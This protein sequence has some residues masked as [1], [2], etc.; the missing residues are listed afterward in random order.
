MYKYFFIFCLFLTFNLSAEVVKKI[1]V[2]GNDR[3][4]DQTVIV[5]GEI[6]L[7]EDYGA[8][9]LDKILKN[10][11]K[12]N[13]FEDVNLNLNNG[14]FKINVKE[15]PIISSIDLRGEKSKTIKKKVLEQLVLKEKESFIE[16]KL[17]QDIEGLKKIYST[18]G[19]NFTTVEAKVEK[20]DNNRIN[21]IYSLNK[22]KKIKISKINFIGNKI[23]RERKLRDIIAS[24]ENRFWKFLSRNTFLNY[25]NIE[26]D[27]RLLLNYY[28]SLGYYD[29]QV[30]S[31]NAEISKLDSTI[32]TYT[33]NA[34]TRY[35]I[36]KISANVSNVLNKKLFSPLQKDFTKIVGK[37]YS[38]FTVKKLLD[39]LDVLI[40]D[41]DLQFIEHSVNEILENEDIEIKINIYEGSKQLVE[42]INIT[43]NSVTDESVIRSELLLDE[44][45]PFNSLKLSKS[46]SRLK[47]R[48]LFS[49][50]KEVIID[51]SS[52]NQK[53]VEIKV[54]EMPTGEISAGA[55][56]GTSGGSIS[57]NLTENN[58]LGRGIA[59]TTFVDASKTTFSGGVNVTD[60]NYKFS[61]NS[62]NYF[63]NN[64]TND[65]PDSGFK[66]SIISTGVGTVFE[67]FKN[68]FISP[69]I[70]L[71][72]D[73]MTVLGT[74]SDG[75]KKQAGSFSDVNLSYKISEDTRNRTYGPTDGDITSFSQSLPLY[76][77]SPYLR[78]TF[79]Y[80]AHEPFSNNIIGSVRFYASAINGLGDKDVRISK[81][82]FLPSSRLRGFE[83]G[84]V[85]PKDGTDYVGGN[86]A[87]ATTLSLQLPNLLPENTKADVGLFFDA[88]NLWKVDYGGGV[89]D[90]NSLR[91]SVGVSTNW[92]S[93]I[94][95]MNFVLAQAITKG[96]TDVTEFFSFR[97]G[98]TF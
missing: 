13:F 58:W 81:R 86:Y 4:S 87:A 31:S 59:V 51:G 43:G 72:Y 65:K 38:P 21:L 64:T 78:N 90:S 9:D 94:G 23:L 70:A 16:N 80:Q 7:N 77:D 8:F 14:V 40:A 73:D 46:I 88:A 53:I 49:D 91:S 62:L 75:L 98:T 30:L 57:F 15:Y 37:Y 36:S 74:A 17:N 93:P 42:R 25:A 27:K 54:E 79:E 28:K 32:L 89:D 52:E 68:I 18:L 26:L 19:F 39:Q 60:P 41:N 2:E 97:L 92:T 63:I 47:G 66:N 35:K 29:V 50:V 96:S 34:G 11:Y 33:V 22:G 20:F 1:V 6:S 45:D 82:I 10:L 67:Q 95:P 55:G 83:K 84:K 56:I 3:I 69:Q 5:Y 71:S 44:G 85:G 48:R 12:T 61:G 76:A 24:E